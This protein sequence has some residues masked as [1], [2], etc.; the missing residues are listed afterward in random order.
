VNEDVILCFKRVLA[1]ITVRLVPPSDVFVEEIR[2]S[3]K[4]PMDKQPAK[5]FNFPGEFCLLD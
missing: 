3:V 4:S 1:E 5:E 2:S